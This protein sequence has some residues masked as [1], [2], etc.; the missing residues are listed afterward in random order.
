MSP[1]SDEVRLPYSDVQ[2]GTGEQIKETD[3]VEFRLLFSGELPS[4]GNKSS[5]SEVHGIRRQFHPQLRRL[6]GAEANLRELASRNILGDDPRPINQRPQPI[7]EPEQF[8]FGI[9]AIG[10]NWSRAGFDW[11]PLVTPNMT[12]RCSIDILLLRPDIE[13]KYVMMRGDIDGQVKTLFDALRIPGSAAETGG[14]TPQ[15]DETPFFCLLE[16]DRLITE[17]RVTTDRLLL[18]PHQGTVKPNDCFAVI[19]VKLNHKNARMFDNWFG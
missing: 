10:A 18:L 9:K 3:L 1:V 19:H 11:V 17:V 16:D 13:E 12:L 8:E 6:W 15:I 2:I 4:T 7:T 14:A 5:P